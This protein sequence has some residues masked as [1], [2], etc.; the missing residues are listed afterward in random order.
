MGKAFVTFNKK[1]FET[2]D[3][4]KGILDND[5]KIFSFFI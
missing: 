5:L 4:L 3:I 2:E 1:I